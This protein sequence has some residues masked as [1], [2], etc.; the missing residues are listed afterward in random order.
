MGVSNKNSVIERA[1]S[2]KGSGLWRTWFVA[3]SA[4]MV[5]AGFSISRESPAAAMRRLDRF[6]GSLGV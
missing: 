6:D 5:D 4:A 2:L 1:L 3:V